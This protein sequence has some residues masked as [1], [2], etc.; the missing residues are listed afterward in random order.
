MEAPFS[1]FA[2]A[3][4]DAIGS[5]TTFPA[6]LIEPLRAFA[7]EG[8]TSFEESAFFSATIASEVTFFAG[9]LQSPPG[10]FFADFVVCTDASEELLDRLTG[11]FGGRS[12]AEAPTTG[13]DP[14]FDRA[15]ATFFE[16][17]P[18]NDASGGVSGARFAPS[19]DCCNGLAGLGVL[20]DSALA[21]L[22]FFLDFF[23]DLDSFVDEAIEPAEEAP[24]VVDFAPVLADAKDS[25]SSETAIMLSSAR[26]V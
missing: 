17:L 22:D 18:G 10:S 21:F 11:L 4:E 2:A 3:S 24:V 7:G 25:D 26:I 5:T 14:L 16:F 6:E 15:T 13:D 20:S 1:I 23:L 12:S 19:I 9:G 8:G